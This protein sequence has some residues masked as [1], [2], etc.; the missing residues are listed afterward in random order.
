VT[1]ASTGVSSASSTIQPKVNQDTQQLHSLS[2]ELKAH[3][4]GSYSVGLLGYCQGEQNEN[5]FTNCSKPSISFS[6][7]LLEIF[8][9]LSNE[10]DNLLPSNDSKV[11]T[12]YSDVSRWT[13]TAYI[14]GTISTLSAISFGIFFM[15]TS[16]GKVMLLISSLVGTVL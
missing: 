6:F 15:F 7:N 5:L 13:I 4:P 10:A 11:L 2:D 1:S 3:L 9:S 12:G 8:S 14:L 16:R